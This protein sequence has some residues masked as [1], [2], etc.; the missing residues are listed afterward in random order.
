[1]LIVPDVVQD[2]EQEQADRPV[3]VDQAQDRGI[4]QDVE[5]IADVGV[6]DVGSAGVAEQRLAVR[7]DDR[8]VIDVDD[9]DLWIDLVRDLAALTRC[10]LSG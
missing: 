8:V 5:R 4:G 9:V 3:E 7:V 6:D 10:R 1:V 2:R